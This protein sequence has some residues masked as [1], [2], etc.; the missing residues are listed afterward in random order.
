MLA[1]GVLAVVLPN[2]GSW[3][4]PASTEAVLTAVGG[5]ILAVLGYLEHPT[6][7]T[8]AKT[9]TVQVVTQSAPKTGA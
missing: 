3:G 9:S 6:T 2:V 4:L 5:G 8:A 7:I 1:S